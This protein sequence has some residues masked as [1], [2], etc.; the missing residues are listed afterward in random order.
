MKKLA[1]GAKVWTIAAAMSAILEKSNAHALL[2]FLGLALG[3]AHESPSAQ[4]KQTSA[5]APAAETRSGRVQPIE[6]NRAPGRAGA[7]SDELVALRRA[8][9]EMFDDLGG[10][11]HSF[12]APPT[13]RS[14]PH[15][16]RQ[17]ETWSQPDP[18]ASRFEPDSI[19]FWAGLTMP[20]IP[21]R[22]DER[23]R[24]YVR[25]FSQNRDGRGVFV[26]WLRRSGALREIISKELKQRGLPQDLIA[27]VF[28]ESG[29]GPTAVSSAGA[30]GLWQLMPRTA[31]AYGLAV[32][33]R[34]D[35]RRSIWRSTEA[36]VSHLSDLFDY[37]RSWDLAL[38]A[39]NYG[40]A[41]LSERI[42]RMGAED[43]WTL[44]DIPGALPKETVLYVPKV[45]A[46]AVLLNN[47]EAFGFGDVKMD[48][49]WDASEIQVPGEIR[50]SLIARA[51]ATSLNR[52]RAMNPEF[53]NDTVPE[54]PALVK[55]HI[56]AAGLARALVMLPTLM[57]EAGSDLA[58]AKVAA[59]FDWG[60]DDLRDGDH[61]RLQHTTARSSYFEQEPRSEM[62]SARSETN[63]APTKVDEATLARAVCEQLPGEAPESREANTTVAKSD[64][65]A[66]AAVDSRAQ[67]P[68]SS[69]AVRPAQHAGA[70]KPKAAASRPNVVLRPTRRVVQPK[71][72]HK[73]VYYRTSSG[74]SAES[75]GRAVGLKPA[76]VLSAN[77]LRPAQQI[78]AGM[79]L[80]LRVDPAVF[81]RLRG[82]R[83]ATAAAGPT[84][85]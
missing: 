20:S 63:L 12:V 44:S 71:T 27:V 48:P 17:R 54:R 53:R 26:S 76:D 18:N 10:A 43:F 24:K 3:G 75:I 6:P 1:V 21:V 82:T 51:A 30:T 28:I 56:P 50:L 16:G 22:H 62:P 42:Q 9:S 11:T 78:D 80:R 4:A 66:D 15:S 77:G 64:S 81:A 38:A 31:R 61:M 2:F 19:G 39:Y 84:K 52:I 33:N 47:L 8:E 41:G 69:T 60:R 34:I 55:V 83:S 45:L 29:F 7:E 74:E 5:Q 37:F 40:Y 25:Y 35:E 49:P 68:A 46:V 23:V 73:V 70:N 67:A 13:D 85:L 57:D 72:G 36:A 79:L 58:D 65:V 59:D 32:E 14:L